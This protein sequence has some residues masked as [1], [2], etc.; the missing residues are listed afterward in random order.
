[1]AKKAKQAVLDDAGRTQIRDF[2]A[3]FAG[4]VPDEARRGPYEARPGDGFGEEEF[5]VPDGVY[6]VYGSDWLITIEDGK[7]AKAERALPPKF[8]GPDVISVPSST[9]P[10]KAPA[11]AE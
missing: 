2:T 5:S 4:K 11:A 9:E 7:F 6:R 8:G 10:T 3:Q 1:M